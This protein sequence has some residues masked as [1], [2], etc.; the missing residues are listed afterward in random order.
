MEEITNPPGGCY[1]GG[2]KR[3]M[4]V[5]TIYPKGLVKVRGSL[6]LSGRWWDC[7][8]IGGSERGE[9]EGFRLEGGL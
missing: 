7:I 2:L 6:S 5:K 4:K 9:S 8:K 3:D 1:A